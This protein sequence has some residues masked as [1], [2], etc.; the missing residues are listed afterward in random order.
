MTQNSLSSIHQ[1]Q[2]NDNLLTDIE[3]L[4][5]LTSLKLLS[6]NCNHLSSLPR[7]FSLLSNLEELDF[8]QN[9][10]TCFDLDP[11]NFPKLCRVCIQGN[12]FNFPPPSLLDDQLI[13][14]LRNCG[15]QNEETCLPLKIV[16][17][18]ASDFEPFAT[19]MELA[20]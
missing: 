10:F 6:L 3:N 14:F 11:K 17:S 1:L 12:K 13:E 9:E 15:E 2:L 8:Q 4:V 20:E 18:V 5:T 7:S 16:K 19:N